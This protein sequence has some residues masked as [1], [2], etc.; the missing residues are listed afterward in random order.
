M[1][2]L[3]DFILLY[4]FGDTVLPG[5]CEVRLT[6]GGAAASRTPRALESVA[7]AT[8][9]RSPLRDCRE[10]GD[11]EVA[12][13]RMPRPSSLRKRSGGIVSRRV[14]MPS[15]APAMRLCTKL[16]ASRGRYRGPNRLC[17]SICDGHAGRAGRRLRSRL[18]NCRRRSRWRWGGAHR[19]RS[20]HAGVLEDV[21]DVGAT[22]SSAWNSSTR[23]SA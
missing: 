5:D 23:S 3:P 17:P 21:G 2:L 4:D 15:K 11:R 7:V 18:Q 8:R 10:F 22:C 16:P 19:W 13:W 14:R 20:A 9:K 12:G 6:T 1:A